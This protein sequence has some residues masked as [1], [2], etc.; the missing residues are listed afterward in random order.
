M[1]C[2]HVVICNPRLRNVA[3]LPIID[4]D[5]THFALTRKTFCEVMPVSPKVALSRDYTGVTG[6]AKNL[7]CPF[8]GRVNK[9]EPPPCPCAR[10]H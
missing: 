9:S 4:G 8:Y 7:L 6:A 5:S 10:M 2:L 1:K 3:L